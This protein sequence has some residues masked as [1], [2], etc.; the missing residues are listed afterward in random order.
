VFTSD[1]KSDN[2]VASFAE[3]TLQV[4]GVLEVCDKVCQLGTKSELRQVT[5]ALDRIM[6]MEGAL[7]A[8]LLMYY[9]TLSGS[10]YRICHVRQFAHMNNDNDHDEN[11][12]FPHVY[13]F[14][15]MS[16]L[17]FHIS[18]WLC[19]LT[20][21]QTALDIRRRVPS[22]SYP[23]S[24]AEA[25][26]AVQTKAADECADNLCMSVAYSMEEKNGYMGLM[27]AVPAVQLSANWFKRQNDEKK[28]HWCGEAM[29]RL[30]GYGL[31]TPHIGIE[32]ERHDSA[33]I[34]TRS[35]PSR[36]PPESA[37]VSPRMQPGA[38][39]G[40]ESNASDSA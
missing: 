37:S 25:P 24:P 16:S 22:R 20:L 17:I 38:N 28:L 36:S 9:K 35:L 30:Q 18:Y 39:T 19:L 14:P 40:R 12:V 15:D 1:V 6:A 13:T 33:S 2:V 27:S 21:R 31:R 11:L 26:L 5:K 34:G 29:Q 23:F 4:A 10:P 32:K 7:N 3:T 8:Y